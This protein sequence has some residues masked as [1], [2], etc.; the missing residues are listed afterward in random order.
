[1][2]VHHPHHPTEKKKWS[3]YLLEFF[4]LFVAVTLGFFAENIREHIAENEKRKEL[5]KSVST[6][7]KRDINQL[8]FHREFSVNKIKICD[9]CG[10]G[11]VKRLKI[12]NISFE[13]CQLCQNRK[14]VK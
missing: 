7:L 4:M 5:I 9:N 1:M 6:E 10:K 2:E 12:L 11:E 8:N 3:E 13:I 14:K